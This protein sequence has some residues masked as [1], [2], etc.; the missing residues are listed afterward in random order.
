[1]NYVTVLTERELQTRFL[2]ERDAVTLDPYR[3]GDRVVRC[4]SCKRVVKAEFAANGCPLCGTTPFVPAPVERTPGRA[5]PARAAAPA[6]TVPARQA[7]AAPAAHIAP[8][9]SR[10]MAL[11]LWLLLLSAAAA[12]LP[13][14]IPDAAAFLVAA[15]F[16]TD[17]ETSLY[18]ILTASIIAAIITY[19][20]RGARQHW[21]CADSGPWLLLIPICTPY[22]I[23]AGIWA[24]LFVLKL[25]LAVIGVVVVFSMLVG[26]IAGLFE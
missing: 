15:T 24:V 26:V 21:R 1:M 19:N 3:V 10:P 20:C 14:A 18:A 16:E 6:R 2:G 13:Y 8:R 23:L 17:S 11:F 7:R 9:R 5:V 25:L 4:A 22:L 12:A